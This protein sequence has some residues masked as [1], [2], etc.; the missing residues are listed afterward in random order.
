MAALSRWVWMVSVSIHLVTSHVLHFCKQFIPQFAALGKQYEDKRLN[1]APFFM[2][3]EVCA[4]YSS[5]QY[6]GQD[7]LSPYYYTWKA[8]K[9]LMDQWDGSQKYWDTQVSLCQWVQVMMII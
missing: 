8:P 4:R 7:N 6:R 5:V 3:G 9:D 2:Y 1:K